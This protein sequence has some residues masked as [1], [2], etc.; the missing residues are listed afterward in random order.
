MKFSFLILLCAFMGIKTTYK[1]HKA[2]PFDAYLQTE[3]QTRVIGVNRQQFRAT[4]S[5]P[6]LK[7]VAVLVRFLKKHTITVG[8]GQRS[9]TSPM[10]SVGFRQKYVA[11]AAL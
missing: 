8:E 4:D 9:V 6:Q 3:H 1:L 7:T 5:V 11:R 10:D 2:M